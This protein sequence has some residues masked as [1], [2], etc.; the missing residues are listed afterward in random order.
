[1][2]LPR[3]HGRSLL[4]QSPNEGRLFEGNVRRQCIRRILF[5]LCTAGLETLRTPLDKRIL[6]DGGTDAPVLPPNP[7]L[8]MWRMDTSDTL[9]SGVLSPEQATTREEA[10]RLCTTASASTHF[11]EEDQSFIEAVKL[12]DWWSSR[13]PS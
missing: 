11:A 3:G 13:T 4:S 10:L 2:K 9:T 7:F 5:S 1:M 6:T 12:A 8:S